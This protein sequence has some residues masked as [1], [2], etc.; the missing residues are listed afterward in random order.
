MHICPGRLYFAT[1]TKVTANALHPGSVTSELVRHSF[2]M[3]WLWKIFSFFLKTPC[4]GAQ[5]SIYCAVAEELE[6][7]TGQYFRWVQAGEV[8]ILWKATSLAGEYGTFCHSS[9]RRDQV[10]GC[11]VRLRVTNTRASPLPGL[12]QSC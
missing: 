3:T 10:R 12:L 8:I 1:G 2:V 11:V 7:V 4:E 9:L 6:S 5:T